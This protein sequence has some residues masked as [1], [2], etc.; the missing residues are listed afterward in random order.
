[1]TVMRTVTSAVRR[2]MTSI[3]GI[4]PQ[5]ALIT[6]IALGDGLKN[7]MVTEKGGKK[8]NAVHTKADGARD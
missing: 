7:R 8:A 5:I 3:S 6:R 2:T 1:M 4:A